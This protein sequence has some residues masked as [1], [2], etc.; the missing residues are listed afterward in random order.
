MRSPFDPI[1]DMNGAARGGEYPTS[2]N[3]FGF[4]KDYPGYGSEPPA[5][6]AKVGAKPSPRKPN[7]SGGAKARPEKFVK[8]SLLAVRK[9]Q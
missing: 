6:G 5:G 7:N 2:E 3:K 8:N 9:G 4:S 1:P